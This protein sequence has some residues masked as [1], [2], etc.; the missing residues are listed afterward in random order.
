MHGDALAA[1]DAAMLPSVGAQGISGKAPYAYFPLDE[2]SGNDV[3]GTDNGS[4]LTCTATN[5]LSWTD[6]T[7]FRR[8]SSDANGILSFS[9]FPDGIGSP[10][11]SETASGLVAGSTVAVS[12]GTTPWTNATE[13]IVYTCTGWKLY[14]DGGNVVSNG[15]ETSFTYTHPTPSSPRRLEWQWAVSEVKGISADSKFRLRPGWNLPGLT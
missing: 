6:D 5:S 15:T 10:S 7:S 3:T 12:C 14:D 13:T 1:A 4:P 8:V 11:P 2:G 9:T